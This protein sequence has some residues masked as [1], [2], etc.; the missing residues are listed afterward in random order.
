MCGEMLE[1]IILL[2]DEFSGLYLDEEYNGLCV[3]LAR[4]LSE[5][6]GFSF[7][8]DG[9]EVWACAIIFAVGQLNF[10][11]EG[12]WD[13]YVDRDMLCGRFSAS[14]TKI[15]AKARD[16]RRLLELKLGDGEFSTEFVLSLDIPESDEDLKR[17]RIFNE[18]KCQISRRP[19]SEE[20][21]DNTE[22]LELIGRVR[23]GEEECLDELYL[24]LRKT[25]FIRPFLGKMVINLHSDDGTFQIPV[26]TSVD[27]CRSLMDEFEDLE[28][29]L[30]PLV[31]VLNFIK[32]R[33][34]RGVVINPNVE[35]FILT[36]E[37]IASVYPNPDRFNY[38]NIFF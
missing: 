6:E 36:E 21:L 20:S 9:P 4:R 24:L 1:E 15:N 35:G 8:R 33:N 28:Y 34:F 29:G 17:I 12:L 7:G 2:I 25:Y 5:T 23:R 3:S 11:F 27:E 26:Y 16:I 30:W 31:N 13:P 22:L 18:V 14:R 19:E 37:M 10:L 38:M 32:N